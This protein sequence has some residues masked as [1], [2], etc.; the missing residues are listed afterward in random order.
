M[1]QFTYKIRVS[2]GASFSR[3][4]FAYNSSQAY[5]QV[6]YELNTLGIFPEETITSIS[7]IQVGEA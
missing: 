3:C 1:K 2:T 7:L 5:M 4:A 6:C